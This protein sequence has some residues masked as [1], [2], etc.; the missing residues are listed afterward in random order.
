MICQSR[1]L[2]LVFVAALFALTTCFQG[3]GNQS[4]F[5]KKEH[6]GT[7]ETLFVDDTTKMV[8]SKPYFV[9]IGVSESET[10]FGVAVLDSGKSKFNGLSSLGMYGGGHHPAMYQVS[11]SDF[12]AIDITNS[13]PSMG[14]I[15]PKN[16]LATAISV[17]D[18]TIRL[19]YDPYEVTEFSGYVSVSS[20]GIEL[21]SHNKSKDTVSIQLRSDGKLIMSG[22]PVATDNAAV[23]KL[24]RGQV[25]IGPG[26]T[27]MIHD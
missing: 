18:Y 22:L 5:A 7:M 12:F 17:E 9:K 4:E 27:L 10:L 11:D 1:W 26:N 13:G 16:R 20:A 15:K 3:C 8:G 23:N 24:E 25:Y 6:S 21:R 19:I 14:M 2:Y